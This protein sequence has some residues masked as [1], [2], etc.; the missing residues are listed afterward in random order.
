[1]EGD[2]SDE[3]L[4]NGKKKKLMCKLLIG[5][6]ILAAVLAIILG[7]IFGLKK[8]DADKGNE[9]K[10]DVEIVDS[11]ENTEELMKK[12]PL[13]N[14]I[15][16]QD[17][18]E[19]NIQNRLLTG[20]ENWNRGYKAWKKWGNILYTNNSIYNVNGVRLTLAQY[21]KAMDASLKKVN[22]QLGA[23]HNM[24]I[25]GEYT[26]IFYDDCQIIDGIAH[27]GTVMEF[28]WFKDY[29]KEL[30]TRVAVGWGGTKG[31]NFNSMR[32]FQGDEERMVQDE[33]IQLLL[34]YQIP[35]I[36]NL[37]EKY[38][39]LYPTEYLDKD[40]DKAKKFIEIILEGFDK[41]NT[42]VETYIEWVNKG[43]TDDALSYGI[44]GEKRTME[45]YK[46]AMQ[47]LASE[48]DIKKLY[49][50]NILVRDDWAAIH[51]QYK[52]EY[53]TTNKTDTGDRMQFFK[54]KE[55]E[56]NYKIEASWIR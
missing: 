52:T 15:T 51:Y 28:V 32:Y 14:P 19:K 34:H 50:Y 56:S 9:T 55:I 2:L 35:E 27:N 8:D 21:Q 5:F 33:K 31:D 13:E 40:K 46:I 20:F 6:I 1:M 48:Q 47:K 3:F 7:L 44:G 10:D 37:A 26:A 43:Y 49:F 30:K 39:I 45:E 42:D 17:G 12:F 4:K 25:N 22:I 18:I 54:F 38:P 29:G 11:Y 41:W 36:K 53:L 24:I 16:I 23:F